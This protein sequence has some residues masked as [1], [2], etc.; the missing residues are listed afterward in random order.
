VDL[1]VWGCNLWVLVG[2]EFRSWVSVSLNSVGG[3]S[4]WGNIFQKRRVERD[5]LE[6]FEEAAFVDL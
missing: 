5:F 3:L 2:R 1:G 4:F 6:A